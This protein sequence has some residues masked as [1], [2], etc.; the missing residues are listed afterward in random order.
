MFIVVI[1]FLRVSQTGLKLAKK[2]STL[3]VFVTLFPRR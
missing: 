3:L 2:V 1:Y